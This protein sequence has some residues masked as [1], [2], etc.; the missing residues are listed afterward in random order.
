MTRP[1]SL[2]LKPRKTPQQARST[3]TVEAICTA[4]IQV[5]LAD[6]PAR[7]NTTRVAVRAGVSVGTMYQYYPNKQAL[8]MAILEQKLDK[9]EAA[10][11]AAIETLA[12]RDLRTIAHGLADGWLKAKTTDIEA[13]RAIYGIAAG[14]DIEARMAEGAGRLRQ[15]IGRLLATAP[16]ARFA[17]ID[18]TAFMTLALLAGSTRA[19]LEHG[20]SD[21]DL[22]CLRRELPRA[23]YGYLNAVGHDA[24]KLRL[25]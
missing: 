7:L 23:C 10:M 17:D 11:L 19:V 13:S 15:G 6:G 8:L 9:V 12:G 25:V 18:A 24:T 1:D 4:T 3:A 5:L 21:H 20:A 14:F 2:P 22:A 16:D